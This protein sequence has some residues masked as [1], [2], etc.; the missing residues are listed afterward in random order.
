MFYIIW[1][2]ADQRY[3]CAKVQS[4]AKGRWILN[5]NAKH[6]STLHIWPGIF[7]N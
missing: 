5:T 1:N 7:M 2:W 6:E 4:R 3:Y